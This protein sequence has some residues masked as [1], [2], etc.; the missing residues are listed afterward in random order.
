MTMFFDIDKMIGKEFEEGLAK[1][2]TVSEAEARRLS[3][4]AADSGNV[5]RAQ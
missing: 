4:G 2:G 3:S 5:A 1:L